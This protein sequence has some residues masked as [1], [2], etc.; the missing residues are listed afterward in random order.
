[1]TASDSERPEDGL[2]GGLPDVVEK[3]RTRTPARIFA[4]RAGATYRTQTQ[5]DLRAA[6]AAARDAVCAEIDIKLGLGEAFLQKWGLF[7]VETRARSK[8]EFLMRPDFGRR[9]TDAAREEV[10]KHCARDVD[11][12]IVI[13]DGL[14]VPAV[15][16][17]VPSLLPLL[18]ASAKTR[19]WKLGQA[20]MVRYCRVGILNEIGELLNP[21]VA[22]LLIGERP[23]LATT[24]SLS[25]YMAYQPRVT[26]TDGNR[27]LISNIHS[28][29]ICPESAAKRIME[30]AAQMML[31]ARSGCDVR[32]QL[33]SLK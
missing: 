7:E 4:G 2:A 14:S 11:F 33:Q 1:M 13:G 16:A 20:F 18:A 23:G 8:D 28:R 32:E 26:H 3:I 5:I 10:E 29:G 6:H 12:Q 15:I 19:E 27:N 25:T 31:V 22:V 17:Q 30:L 24:E 21:R 9:F